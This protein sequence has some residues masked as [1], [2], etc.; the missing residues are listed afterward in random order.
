MRLASVPRLPTA[1]RS[2]FGFHRCSPLGFHHCSA[3][4]SADACLLWLQEVGVKL[5]L[6]GAV[7]V[8]EYSRTSVPSIWAA[9]ATLPH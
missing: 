1:R 7:D 3:P 2:P 9:R 5:K 4:P 8:D 6:S